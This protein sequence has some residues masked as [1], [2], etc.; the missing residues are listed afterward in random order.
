MWILK[1][2]QRDVELPEPPVR[3]AVF[4]LLQDGENPSSIADS[5]RL[6]PRIACAA[7]LS[8]CSFPSVMGLPFIRSP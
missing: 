5:R 6:T 3:T 1:S 7:R 4:D 8:N 2:F